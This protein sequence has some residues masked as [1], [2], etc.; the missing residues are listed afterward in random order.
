M[1]VSLVNFLF[2]LVLGTERRAFLMLGGHSPREL[3]K[4]LQGALECRHSLGVNIVPDNK[5]N[6]FI[7]CEVVNAQFQF[8][9]CTMN[10]LY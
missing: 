6:A 3:S 4:S 1:P 9:E 5:R 8:A 10:L 2:F 7:R